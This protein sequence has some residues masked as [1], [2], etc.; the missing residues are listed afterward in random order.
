MNRKLMVAGLAARPVRTT[1]SIMAVALEVILI[2]TIVGV[3]NGI[4]NET[5]QR[6][7]GVGADIMF[8]APNSSLLLALSNSSLPITLGRKIREIE[9]V[10]A[11]APVQ[12]QVN[13]SAGLEIIYGIEPLTFDQITG[14]FVWHSGR[15]F[16]EANEVVIDDLYSRAKGIRIGDD[17]QLLNHRFKVV[18]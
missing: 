1:V 9:G 16:S 12:V 17:L 3:A 7:Q 4:T 13:S 8:Q 15:M 18:G 10:K 11:V 6:T 2:L 14:G 5:G